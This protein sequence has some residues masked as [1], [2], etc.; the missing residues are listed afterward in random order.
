[1][2]NG[3]LAALVI[4]A[5]QGLAFLFGMWVIRKRPLDRQ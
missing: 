2:L 4:V 1:M 3:L 5:I